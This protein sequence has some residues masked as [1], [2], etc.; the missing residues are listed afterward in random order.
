VFNTDSV[1]CEDI[2][3]KDKK[4]KKKCEW[5]GTRKKER[6]KEKSGVFI[7]Y[8]FHVVVM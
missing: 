4:K 2:E 8:S 1:R 7:V 5:H 6:E 3:D